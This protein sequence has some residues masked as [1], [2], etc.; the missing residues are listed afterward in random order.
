MKIFIKAEERN[1]RTKKLTQTAR[2]CFAE[3]INH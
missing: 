1:A 2:I 3:I